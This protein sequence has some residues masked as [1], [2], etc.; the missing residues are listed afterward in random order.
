MADE[1]K[2]GITKKK[3]IEIE[4]NISPKE[5]FEKIGV[6]DGTG[7]QNIERE[8]KYWAKKKK[9]NYTNQ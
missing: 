8:K 9:K 2:S 4:S 1:T 7:K 3:K 5:L 6:S